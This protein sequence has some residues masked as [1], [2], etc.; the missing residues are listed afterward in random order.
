MRNERRRD[1]RIVLTMPSHITLFISIPMRGGIANA[2]RASGRPHL[3]TRTR[4]EVWRS[5]LRKNQEN[6]TVQQKNTI[7]G[8][9]LALVPIAIG[10]N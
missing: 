5:L 3:H 2:M 10:S 4:A 8:T 7:I 9:S 6:T 1:A